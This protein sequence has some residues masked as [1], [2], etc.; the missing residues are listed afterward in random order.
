MNEEKRIYA[1]NAATTPVLPEVVEAMIPCFNEFWG[2]PSSMHADGQ[3]AAEKLAEAR[4][5]IANIIGAQPKEI[6]FT[7]CGSESDNWAIK[8]AAKM[9]KAG[10]NKIVT[11][12]IEHPAVMQTCKALEKDGFEVVY[13]G[14][15][16]KGI[17][18]MNELAAAIDEKTAV[19]AIMLANN[20][21]GTIQP[22]AEVSKLAKAAGLAIRSITSLTYHASLAK[23]AG[24]NGRPALKQVA[25]FLLLCF[26]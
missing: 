6:Y 17:L 2:N 23:A 13:V 9:A 1:D 3:A 18:D 4:E 25:R 16:S 12:K 11:S 19:V 21:I 7:S 5:T 10:R 24:L 20:E 14:V 15:D 22:I 26:D 8:G